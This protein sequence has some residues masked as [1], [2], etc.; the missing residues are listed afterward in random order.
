MR[1]ACT[2]GVGTCA[3]RPSSCET[4]VRPAPQLFV[5][6]FARLAQRAEKDTAPPTPCSAGGTRRSATGGMETRKCRKMRAGMAGVEPTSRST[7]TES[8]TMPSAQK[9]RYRMRFGGG[10][11]ICGV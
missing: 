8:G 5:W 9:C 2:S 11:G 3:K 7:S 4:T 10:T 1:P 6:H